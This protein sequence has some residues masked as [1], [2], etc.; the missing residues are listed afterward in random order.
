[1]DGARNGARFATS[2]RF[3]KTPEPRERKPRE[4]RGKDGPE[5]EITDG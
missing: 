2:Q 4:I 5:G 3:R 1:M